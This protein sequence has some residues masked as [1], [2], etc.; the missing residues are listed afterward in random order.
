MPDTCSAAQ[1]PGDSRQN[2][3]VLGPCCGLKK[4]ILNRAR[5]SA[6]RFT[7]REHTQIVSGS[8]DAWPGGRTRSQARMLRASKALAKGAGLQGG[9]G[10]LELGTLAMARTMSTASELKA[11]LAEKIPEE[12]VSP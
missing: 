12:Q 11:V 5:P 2:P 4:S 8:L 3:G 10:L 7:I 6:G 9:A 1:C